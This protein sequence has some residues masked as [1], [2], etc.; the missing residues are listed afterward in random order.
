MILHVRRIPNLGV[1]LRNA[2]MTQKNCGTSMQKRLIVGK[3]QYQ[4][5]EL[6]TS[7]IISACQKSPVKKLRKRKHNPYSNLTKTIVLMEYLFQM[8]QVFNQ[9]LLHLTYTPCSQVMSLLNTHLL[10]Q[11]LPQQPFRRAYQP[12][13]QHQLQP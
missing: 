4:L 13:F 11:V 7:W 6:T 10:Y 1:K 8:C 12:R 5:E 9:L 3:E 2:S